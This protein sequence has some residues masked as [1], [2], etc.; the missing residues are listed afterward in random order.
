MKTHHFAHA[1]KYRVYDL[2]SNGIVATSIIIGSILLSTNELLRV[3]QLSIVSITDLIWISNKSDNIKKV[4]YKMCSTQC[5]KNSK[6]AEM[7]VLPTT[8]GS[9][10]MKTARGT[11]F[12][13]PVSLKKVPKLESANE[14]LLSTMV[15]SGWKPCSKQYS[16][17]HE[18]PIW[19]PAWPMC[20]EMHSLWFDQN[21]SIDQSQCGGVR[22]AISAVSR[23][24]A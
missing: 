3:I 16:S 1:V 6:K 18:L 5:I 23:L 20:I 7:Q 2:L 4:Q 10:S 17:Q 8:V 13:A 21:T 12:P 9:K 24:Y 11:Y 19:I 22:K 14:R 15:P